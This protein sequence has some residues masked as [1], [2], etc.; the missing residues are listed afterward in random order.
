M[1]VEAA[2]PGMAPGLV[3]DLAA[4][5]DDIWN[6]DVPEACIGGFACAKDEN[7]AEPEYSP[8]VAE[9]CFSFSCLLSHW[10]I[11]A[12]LSKLLRDSS[13]FCLSA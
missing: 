11:L 5:V 3:G 10:I 8:L 4:K 9:V 1:A 2:A 6:F 12:L 7:P 13:N